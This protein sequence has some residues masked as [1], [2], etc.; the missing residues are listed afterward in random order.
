[1]SHAVCVEDVRD[2]IPAELRVLRER[3]QAQPGRVRAELEPLMEQVVEDAVFR[4]RVLSVARDALES[5]RHQLELA[6]F[7]LDATRR[8]REALARRLLGGSAS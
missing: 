2:A 4:S 8:E 1:M 5:L 6:R 3:L 7:D